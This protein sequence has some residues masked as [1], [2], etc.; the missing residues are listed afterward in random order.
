MHKTVLVTGAN[1]GIGKAICQKLEASDFNVIATD[2]SN[3][4]NY[5]NF[6]EADLMKISHSKDEEIVFAKSMKKLLKQ[7]YLRM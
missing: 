4:E 6:I 1:G 2:I 5:K 7:S 3:E